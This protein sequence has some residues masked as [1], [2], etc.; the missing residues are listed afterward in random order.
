MMHFRSRKE[1]FEL[2]EP[3]E[4]KLAWWWI[5]PILAS[6]CL[7]VGLPFI[8]VF[9]LPTPLNNGDAHPGRFI[10][11]RA[12]SVLEGLV[13]IGPRPTGTVANEVTT[14]RFLTD[15][16]AE[17]AAES[18]GLYTIDTDIQISSGSFY[19]SGYPTLFE[20]IQ[21][22]IVKLT[23]KGS[24]DTN[25]LLLNSHFDTV[26]GSPGAGDDGSMVATMLELLS[27]LTKSKGIV[28]HTIIFLFNGDE[29]NGLVA[30]RAFITKHKWAGLVRAFINLESMGVGGKEMLFQSDP[31]SRWMLDY[32]VKDANHPFAS[33]I[34][35]EAYENHY[36]PSNT[37]YTVFHDIGGL[38]GLNF[39]YINYGYAYHSPLDKIEFVENGSLQ[40][41]GDNLLAIV[42]AIAN[43]N[44]LSQPKE[45]LSMGKQVYFDVFG[46]FMLNYSKELGT[47]INCVIGILSLIAIGVS[48]WLITRDVDTPLCDISIQFAIS[49]GIQLCSLAVAVGVTICLAYLIDAVGYSMAWFSQQWLIFGIYVCPFIFL[50]GIFPALFL[51]W[52]KFIFLPPRYSIL[53]FLHSHCIILVLIIFVL[54]GMGI[55]STFLMTNVVLF[56]LLSLV[57]NLASGLYMKPRIWVLPILWCQ[58]VPLAFSS[59]IMAILF[60][61]FIPVTGRSTSNPEPLIA[62]LAMTFCFLMFGFLIPIVS[63]LQRSKTIITSIL[64]VFVV[65]FILTFT[66][67]CFP[68][69]PEKPERQTVIYSQ[70]TRYNSAGEATYNDSLYYMTLWD[71]HSRETIQ[72]IAKQNG[73]KLHSDQEDESGLR[74]Y[75]SD[76]WIEAPPLQI[77][78]PTGLRLVSK[79]ALNSTVYKYSFE[80]IGRP[81]KCELFIAPF[82]NASLIDWSFTSAGIEG[83]QPS[84]QQYNVRVQFGKNSSEPYT[85]SLTVKVVSSSDEALS[86][87]LLAMYL[88]DVSSYPASFKNFLQLFPNWTSIQCFRDRKSVV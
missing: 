36:I 83:P 21:N 62:L 43:S 15:K 44:E 32:Y 86:L 45:S 16:I 25:A 41:T 5:I 9:K 46:L 87:G 81:T 54:T 76:F 19:D 33:V 70:R 75:N 60:S 72:D 69:T 28:R 8:A 67:V 3:P 48:I 58:V 55:R 24:N 52:E 77:T 59:Y 68:Y 47:A 18:Q 11:A 79:E 2:V 88:E 65:F 40:H 82:N 1:D 63:I 74:Y 53:L 78:N 56:Y 14:V 30:S 20:S 39:A 57:I 34:G 71:S 27:D 51:D 29:E 38:S 64:V 35:E 12:K 6:I 42:K 26:V 37:D 73:F 85:F 31:G 66:E 80:M 22:V 7:I 23:P 49:F 13:A 17:I 84:K 4:E 61:V 10:A 50:L